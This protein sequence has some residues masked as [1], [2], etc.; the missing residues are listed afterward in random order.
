MFINKKTWNPLLITRLSGF[1][2][3]PFGMNYE[4]CVMVTIRICKPSMKLCQAQATVTK[5][6]PL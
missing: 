5:V 1:L 6:S 3:A 2:P 4:S